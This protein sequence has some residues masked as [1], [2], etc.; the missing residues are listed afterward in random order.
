M[1]SQQQQK[2]VP[3]QD[4]EH[5]NG[6][7]RSR[8]LA[9]PNGE[10]KQEQRGQGEEEAGQGEQGEGALVAVEQAMEEPQINIRMAVSHL[11]CHACV[12]PL[13]PPTFE[14]SS[15]ADRIERDLA[16]EIRLGL[17]QLRRVFCKKKLNSMERGK[18]EEGRGFSS[19]KSRTF[20][21]YLG[22]FFPLGRVFCAM[23]K[24]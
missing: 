22:I 19:R 6:A 5:A 21:W 3:D 1:S 9:I 2:R 15:P 4:G 12:L 18:R 20:L 13:K 16:G 23:M 7:K 10:V 11:H 8:A 24:A 14:V 17:F